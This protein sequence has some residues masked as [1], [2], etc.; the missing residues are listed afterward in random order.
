MVEWLDPRCEF[1]MVVDVEHLLA[2]RNDAFRP[3][4]WEH[5]SFPLRWARSVTVRVSIGG[6]AHVTSYHVFG[7]CP[8]QR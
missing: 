2:S 8:G 5:W 1:M 7:R 6:A 4:W 3:P